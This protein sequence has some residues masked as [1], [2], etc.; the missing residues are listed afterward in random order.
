MRM[1]EAM[2]MSIT[3]KSVILTYMRTFNKL[4]IIMK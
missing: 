2:K 3:H 1:R 4:Q